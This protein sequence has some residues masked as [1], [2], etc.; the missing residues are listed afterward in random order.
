[1]KKTDG[2]PYVLIFLFLLIKVSVFRV[3]IF[4]TKSILH[5]ALIEFP[6]WAF[7][8]SVV[9]LLAK[10][11]LWLAVWIFNL[12]TSVIFFVVTLY[13]RYYSTIPSYYDLQQLNQSSSVS[14][15]ITMLSTP[16]DFLFFLDAVLLLFL[17]RRWKQPVKPAAMKY[18]AVS[19]AAICTVT[20]VYALQQPIIDVS[21]FAKENGFLQSQVVQLYNRSTETAHASSSKLSAKELEELKGNEFVKV[22]EQE[23]FGVAEGRNLFVIQVESL[24]NFVIGRTLNGQEITPNL[25]KLLTESAYFSNVFQQ[26]G[27][28]TTSDAEWMTNTG[29]YPQGMIPTA[30]SL[31]GKEA[32]SLARTLKEQGYGSATYHADDVTFWN[33]DVLYPVLGYEEI[34]SIDDLPDI[35]NVGFGPADEV[36]FDFAANEL[37]RQLETYERIY[38]NIVTVTSHTPFEMPESMQHLNLPSEYQDMYIGNYLQSIRYADEQIGVF[39]QELKDQGIYDESL[40]AIFGD[41][42]GMHGTL[43]TEEDQLLLGD[44]LGHDY[45]LKDQYT[46]PLIFTGGNLFEEKEMTRLAGQTDIMPTLL[47]LLGVEHEE[48]MM[49]HNLFQ[50]K[51]NLLGMRYYLPGGSYIQSEQFYKAPGAKLPEVLYDLKTMEERSKNSEAKKHIKDTETL[52]NYADL[53][54]KDYIEE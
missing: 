20:V 3:L 48:P 14:G 1:M 53:L 13:I 9:L 32:P 10:K 54:L 23:S 41:H 4:D 37:P 5:I 16:W 52:M 33:R 18:V 34:F 36:L 49:G 11:K 21:Y 40:I 44:F 15:T 19:M 29:L 7:L 43:V 30:N 38:A 35:K 25:N 50:Y 2:L 42:S 31:S 24:Q 17:V 47:A 51:K 45:S 8:L 26:V 46:I 6:M 12:L 27:A 28:G 39:I 22:S